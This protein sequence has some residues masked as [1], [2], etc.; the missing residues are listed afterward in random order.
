MKKAAKTL[1]KIFQKFCR[2][3]FEEG[4]GFTGVSLSNLCSRDIVV[5]VEAFGH[6][7]LY[8]DLL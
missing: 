1:P 5:F 7:D 4:F 6:C 2:G 8:I 3:D